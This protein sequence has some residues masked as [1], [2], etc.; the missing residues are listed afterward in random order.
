M[1]RH[2]LPCLPHRTSHTYTYTY[3]STVYIC[4]GDDAVRGTGKVDGEDM[5]AL[6]STV[7]AHFEDTREGT[8]ETF[9]QYVDVCVYVYIYVMYVCMHVCIRMQIPWSLCSYRASFTI[10]TRRSSSTILIH[11]PITTP[12]HQLHLHTEMTTQKDAFQK[13]FKSKDE[14]FRQAYLTLAAEKER[15]QM[16]K[17]KYVPLF[18]SFIHLHNIYVYV[19]LWAHYHYYVTIMLC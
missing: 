13:M 11:I 16:S 9:H 18:S 8:I 10:C 1:L 6:P 7:R 2:I 5:V 15:I 14:K 12:L 17:N 4:I 19:S 3:W